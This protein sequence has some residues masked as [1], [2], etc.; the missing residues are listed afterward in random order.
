M[1]FIFKQYIYLFYWRMIQKKP[2]NLNLYK[3]M[4]DN[5]KSYQPTT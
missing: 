2:L 4:K 5:Y 3:D 1:L